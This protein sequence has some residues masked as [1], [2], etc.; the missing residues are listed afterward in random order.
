MLS[1]YHFV[2]LCAALLVSS[3]VHSADVGSNQHESEISL[4]GAIQRANAHHPSLAGFDFELQ[5][6]RAEEAQSAIGPS[7]SMKFELADVAGTG[8]Y[9][10]LDSAQATLGIAWLIEGSIRQG[11]QN[12]A[13]AQTR[14]TLTEIDL[15][16]LEIASETAR[17]YI[18]SLANQSRFETTKE[19]VV[20]AEK[21][22]DEIRK[23]L[24]A[25]RA[26]S[27][28]LARAEAELAR[29]K[30]GAEDIEH[31]M[32]SSY[33]LL[34]A[35]WG[36]TSPGFSK[37]SGDIYQLPEPVAFEEL[38]TRLSQNPDYVRLRM[39]RNIKQAALKLEK[40]KASSP[41]EVN[42]GLRHFES[43]QDQSLV[44][45]ISIPFGKRS[46]NSVGIERAQAQL[47]GVDAEEN[48]L[49]IHFKTMLFVQ[50]QEYL[51]S[52]HRIE[53]FRGQIIPKLESALEETRKAYLLGRYSYLEWQSV[54]SDLL[55]AKTEL[56][57]SSV[58]AHLK[59]IEIE[60]LTGVQL[61]Q[62]DSEKNKD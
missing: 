4:V 62:S 28:E 8:E 22:V 14:T 59:M 50:Y 60:R 32:I 35:Q 11:Y 2:I 12:V 5:T 33:R 61:S 56:L 44:V 49:K 41:W 38:E 13:S 7:P 27:A 20:L 51:H 18:L 48:V 42:L 21:T 1:K 55:S 53:T 10:G 36:E 31:E 37:V 43:T 25:G 46:R 3:K 6:R 34:A 26:A 30:L 39:Q 15:K 23:R 19:S 58:D 57:E 17:F 24:R 54:Q 45:G 47:A 40:S 29:R 9:S 52:L 16:R